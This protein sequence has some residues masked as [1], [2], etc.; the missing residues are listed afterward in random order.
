MW[1]VNWKWW[2]VLY[3]MQ[4]W[5][6]FLRVLTR[7]LDT[8]SGHS[9]PEQPDQCCPQTGML[10]EAS[11]SVS[12]VGLA[13]YF[14]WGLLFLA[15][16]AILFFLACTPCQGIC[17]CCCCFR[18]K[19]VPHMNLDLVIPYHNRKSGFPHHRKSQS[20]GDEIEPPP[21]TWGQVWVPPPT[22]I[23][24]YSHTGPS[25]S[26]L[27]PHG[28]KSEPTPPTWGQV[29]A[30][31]SY[32]P[33]KYSWYSLVANLYLKSVILDWR[34]LIDTFCMLLFKLLKS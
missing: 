10:S 22:C 18:Q 23:S 8:W 11:V 24:P 17:C 21:P 14:S 3:C 32:N 2:V 13:V 28:A 4:I 1:L 25:L 29:R 27:L 30:F 5:T 6:L 7:V 19:K 33:S 15:L 31:I 12:L 9:Q 16:I 26:P 20:L 34:W